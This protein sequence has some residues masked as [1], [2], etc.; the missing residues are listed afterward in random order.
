MAANLLLVLAT[1]PAGNDRADRAGDVVEGAAHR[2]RVIDTV[3]GPRVAVQVDLRDCLHGSDARHAHSPS[4]EIDRG[5]C[6]GETDE[7]EDHA[8]S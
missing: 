2:G 8:A 6:E 3:S 5:S 1:E 4:H 7:K